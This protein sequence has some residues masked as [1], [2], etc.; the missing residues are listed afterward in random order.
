MRRTPFQLVIVLAVLSLVAAA[1]SDDA[2]DAPVAEPDDT[3]TTSDEPTP[4][5]PGPVEDTPTVAATF[6]TSPSPG[7]VSITGATPGNTLTL[8]GGATSATG[9]VDDLGSL[10]FRLVKP[11]AGYTVRDSTADP[12]MM[13]DA[14]TVPELTGHPDS[15]FYEVQTLDEGFQY[16]ETRDGTTLSAYV[17]LPGPVEDGPYPTVVEYS[18]YNPSDPISGLGGLG[19]DFDVTTLCGI[20]PT[21]CKAPAQPGSLLAGLFGY[22]VV[23][24][25]VRGTGCSGGAYDFFE[26][27]QVLDGYDVIE[28]VAAQPWVKNNKV[29]MVGLSYPG[30][31]QLFVAQTNPPSL[32]AIAPLSVY[33]DTASGILAPGGLLNTGFATSWADQVLSNAEPYGTGWVQ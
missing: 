28:T 33:G 18:G 27:M 20:F 8:E 5:E 22:A 15:S 14:V 21:L 1:C 31:S 9:T 26:T 23:G 12:V 24:V 10:L 19:G 11:G 13:S 30:I 3:P 2:A 29:G 7:Q 17:V 16:I 32:A 25:N 6:A 4:D